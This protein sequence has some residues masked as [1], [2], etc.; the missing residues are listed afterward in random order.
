MGAER[1]ICP[2]CSRPG[3]EEHGPEVTPLSGRAGLLDS[4][5]LD[6]VPLPSC[7]T[8]QDSEGAGAGMARICAEIG[9][10]SWVEMEIV[11]WG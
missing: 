10:G 3:V 1:R 4:V 5:L 6:S 11:V 8:L 2:H 9:R 7:F